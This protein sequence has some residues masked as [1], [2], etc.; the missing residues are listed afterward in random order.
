MIFF[1]TIDSDDVLVLFLISVLLQVVTSNFL[2]FALV[3]LGSRSS[4][5][6]IIGLL[7]FLTRGLLRI[8]LLANGTTSSGLTTFN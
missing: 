4:S 8:Y 3:V 1:S 7:L 5:D 2:A 6:V